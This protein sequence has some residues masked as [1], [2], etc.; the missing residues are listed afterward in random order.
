M[1]AEPDNKSLLARTF[2]TR[3]YGVLFASLKTFGPYVIVILSLV[4][5][6]DDKFRRSVF[7]VASFSVH[8]VSVLLCAVLYW[9]IEKTFD[10]VL[11]RI[12]WH[13]VAILP[14]ILSISW[15]FVCACLCSDSTKQMKNELF[16]YKSDYIVC[17]SDTCF[18]VA[19]VVIDAVQFAIYL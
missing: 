13:T 11:S 14:S 19:V 2:I 16:A 7:V 18:A 8:C 3:Q 9:K 15:K 6:N 1:S 5:R 4:R 10:G 17:G 12:Q